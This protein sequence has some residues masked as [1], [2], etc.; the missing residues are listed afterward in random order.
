LLYLLVFLILA[1]INI[2]KMIVT[3]WW[4]MGNRKKKASI[5]ERDDN[6]SSHEVDDSTA[7]PLHDALITQTGID[8]DYRFPINPLHEQYYATYPPSEDP[9]NK[10]QR[11]ETNDGITSQGDRSFDEKN[12]GQPNNE[13]HTPPREQRGDPE[14]SEE[15]RGERGEGGERSIDEEFVPLPGQARRGGEGGEGERGESI[16][17]E[18]MIP[19]HRDAQLSTSSPSTETT[20]DDSV[21]V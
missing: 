4:N 9:E 15:R 16:Q 18:E 21:M 12:G 6:R 10:S 20:E 17:E 14:D 8:D 5:G 3:S 2:K 13:E 1:S 7:S 19:T 11:G